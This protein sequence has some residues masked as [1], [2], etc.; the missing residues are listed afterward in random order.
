MKRFT[1]R[2]A[3][4]AITTSPPV[5][6]APTAPQVVQASPTPAV[7]PDATSA[8]AVGGFT[9]FS[10]SQIDRAPN[11]SQQLAATEAVYA[12]QTEA[13]AKAAGEEEELKRGA[14]TDDA[15]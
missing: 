8:H 2:T 1:Q 14:G 10:K 12:A 11:Q 6:A 15:A 13:A 3:L 7:A 5:A 9:V 4:S